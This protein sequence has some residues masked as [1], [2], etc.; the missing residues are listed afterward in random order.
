V[1]AA[2]AYVARTFAEVLYYRLVVRPVNDRSFVPA[3]LEAWGRLLDQ[4]GVSHR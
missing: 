4:A 3:W 2:P 1:A